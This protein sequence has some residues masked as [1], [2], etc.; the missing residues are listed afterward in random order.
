M[1]QD[2]AR[3]LLRPQVAAVVTAVDNPFVQV[4]VD[5]RADRRVAARLAL[6]GD[7]AC[8]ARP[9]AGAGALK[10]TQEAIALGR[11]VSANEDI[12]VALAGWAGEVADSSDEANLLGRSV[13]DALVTN[14]PDWAG[15]DADDVLAYW[16]AATQGRKAH[17]LDSP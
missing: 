5:V 8:V 12:D 1:M 15:M 13:G 14:S 4:V 16:A 7:A 10:A 3:A 6:I 2:R 9:H 11:W 17:Y